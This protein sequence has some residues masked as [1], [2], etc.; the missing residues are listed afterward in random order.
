MPTKTIAALKGRGLAVVAMIGA[1]FLAGSAGLLLTVPGGFASPLFPA[2]G[3]ALAMVLHRGGSAV[4]AVWVGSLLMNLVGSYRHDDPIDGALL[5]SSLALACGNALQ[6]WGGSVI[7]RHWMGERWR[8]LDR[9]YDVLRLLGGGGAL[10]GLISASWG[11]SSLVLLGQMPSGRYLFEWWNWYVGDVLGVLLL[12]PPAILFLG[13]KG[14]SGRER[15]RGA[16]LPTLVMLLLASVAF[17]A[18]ARWEENVERSRIA[19]QGQ[20]FQ[21]LLA[22]HM[23]A[24]RDTLSGL[25]RAL[26]L[27]RQVDFAAFRQLGSDL[28]QTNPDLQAISYNPYVRHAERP[29]FERAMRSRL[30]GRDFAIM[31][32]DRSGT[33][34]VAEPRSAYVPVAL[35]LPIAGNH[36]AIGYDIASDPERRRALERANVSGSPTMTGPIRLVQLPGDATGVLVVEPVQPGEGADRDRGFAVAVLQAQALVDRLRVDLPASEVRIRISDLASPGLPLY[37][38][39]GGEGV[40][41]LAW[42]ATLAVLDRDWAISLEPTALGLQRNRPW[43]SWAVGAFGILLA[44]LLQVIWLGVTSRAQLVRRQVDDQ[45]AE[46]QTTRRELERSEE[47]YRTLFEGARAPMML[48]DPDSDGRIIDA[49][50][51]A[52][53]FYG[54]DVAALRL[55]SIRDIEVRDEQGLFRAPGQL[56]RTPGERFWMSHRLASDEVRDVEVTT[57][58]LTIGGRQLQLSIVT[59]ITARRRLEDATRRQVAGLT[60]LNSLDEL[61]GQTLSERLELALGAAAVWLRLPAGL[62]RPARADGPTAEI[63]HRRDETASAD[64][65]L[66]A[67]ARAVDGLRDSLAVRDVFDDP[68]VPPPLRHAGVRAFISAPIWVGG[69]RCGLVAFA[70]W[71]P[72][73]RAFDGHDREFVHFLA[74]WCGHQIEREQARAELTRQGELLSGALAALDEAFAIFDRDDRLVFF[75]EKLRAVYPRM[76]DVIRLGATFE[77]LIR[78]GAEH[79]QF[80]DAEGRLDEWVAETM[81]AHRRADSISLQA[82]EGGRWVQVREHHAGDGFTV[83]FRIDVTELICARQDAEA[84]NVA[85]SRFLATMSHEIRT[86]MNG[87]LGMAEMLMDPGLDE[88]ERRDYA[89]MISTSGRTLMGILNDVLDLSKVEAGR[90]QTAQEPF[91]PG[92]LLEEVAG[93][94]R[95]LADKKGLT[96]EWNWHGAERCELSGD[97]GRIRQMLGNLVNNAIK[98]T[99]SGGVR[100]AGRLELSDRSRPR[101]RID[102]S[103]T[104]IGVPEDKRQLLFQPFSQVDDGNTRRFGGSGLGLSIVARMAEL[105]GGSSGFDPQEVGSNFWFTVRVELEDA[106]MPDATPAADPPTVRAVGQRPL[107]LVVEDNDV[108]AKVTASVLRSRGFD[109]EIAGDGAHAVDCVPHLK[110][111]LILM[112][113]HMPVMDGFE[114]TRRIRRLEADGGLP[115]TPIVALTAA[116]F[117]EDRA[118]CLD[119]GMDDHLAKPVDRERLALVVSQW[120]NRAA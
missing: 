113:C 84:A 65:D 106:A 53:D 73:H 13:S 19:A 1:Y 3:I 8:R 118:R 71:L 41:K 68:T 22:R 18:A 24:L 120:V 38:D 78:Y 15:L 88:A 101:L 111:A 35:I 97:A 45:T 79:G 91:L 115:R 49:N 44:A 4:L 57:G 107:V 55:M 61:G 92:Q 93:L 20:N 90:M 48:I 119:A 117:A 98:F 59:D 39:R 72:H 105:L 69:K 114:A 87:I 64:G 81:E 37:E 23:E 82:L 102:V 36:Y 77:D 75:N 96:V 10:A 104:G 34:V 89:S 99:E 58:P 50:Q 116:A 33:L 83:G 112:D 51:A 85:K 28:L 66:G 80:R 7:V 86:P 52:A 67:L 100:L 74:R 27:N 26:E 94:F 9:E 31:E 14:P 108:N 25:R 95:G 2:A 70:D 56:Q 21:T 32:R 16:L 5:V 103:D 40:A 76:Q 17:F 110:P 43:V 63:L 46:I 54:R 12:A 29:A 109:V 30:P 47:R 6:A 11:V 60:V 42:H 62:I